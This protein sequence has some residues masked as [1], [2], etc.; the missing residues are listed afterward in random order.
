VC[1][2]LLANVTGCDFLLLPRDSGLRVPVNG[3]LQIAI[4]FAAL[5]AY[6]GNNL[7]LFFCKVRATFYHPG[8]AQVFPG[9]GVVRLQGKRTLVIAN[10]LIRTAKLTCGVAP[11]VPGF[12]RIA[13]FQGI[14]QV[15]RRLILAFFAR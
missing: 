2:K 9:F 11:V 1:C 8:F 13:V 14:E 15:Q 3:G 12:C 4:L 10:P 5:A 7:Q 6:T